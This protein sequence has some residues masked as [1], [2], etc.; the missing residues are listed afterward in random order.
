MIP[1]QLQITVRRRFFSGQH[2]SLPGIAAVGEGDQN[3][4][5]IAGHIV[6][7]ESE[8]EGDA[9]ICP[10]HFVAETESAG[11]KDDMGRKAGK[12]AFFHKHM[13]NLEFAAFQIDGFVFKILDGNGSF[14]ACLSGYS[15]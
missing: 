7:H 6:E 3:H 1:E 8:R 14:S 13:M 10:Y 2:I 11:F 9:F 5:I 12:A 4:R 15:R